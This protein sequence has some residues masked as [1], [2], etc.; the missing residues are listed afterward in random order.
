[1]IARSFSC[2]ATVLRIAVA[3]ESF[4]PSAV[5]YS[6]G[7]EEGFLRRSCVQST[8]LGQSLPRMRCISAS[9]QADHSARYRQ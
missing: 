1:M 4:A 7:R 6:N 3:A 5:S 2:L 8:A 9:D